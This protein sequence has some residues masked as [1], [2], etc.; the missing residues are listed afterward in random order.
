MN[1]TQ[2]ILDDILLDAKL[3]FS[4]AQTA[5]RLGMPVDAFYQDYYN[6]QLKV[7]D[8]YDSG[9]AQGDV[10]TDNQLYTLAK[11]GSL[12]AKEAYDKKKTEADLSNVFYEIF[13]T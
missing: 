12:S 4:I 3:G 5:A 1:Y 13:N 2:Q 11:N 9:K 8:Y 7:R 10:E 6:S